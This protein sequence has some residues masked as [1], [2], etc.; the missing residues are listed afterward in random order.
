MIV[1]PA[2]TTAYDTIIRSKLDI[3]KMTSTV[4]LS[5]DDRINS[6]PCVGIGSINYSVWGHNMHLM[7]WLAYKLLWKLCLLIGMYY[8]LSS[9]NPC[10][11][12]PL[13]ASFSHKTENYQ[14]PARHYLYGSKCIINK[15]YIRSTS[16]G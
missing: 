14:S 1:T 5:F 3:T 8:L 7:N 6:T 9:S 16:C 15:F 4:L 12:L 2:V 13:N 10:L 11:R